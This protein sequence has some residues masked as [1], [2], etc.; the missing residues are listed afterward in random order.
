MTNLTHKLRLYAGVTLFTIGAIAALPLLA[1][2]FTG[3]WMAARAD[4]DGHN[5]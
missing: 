3:F 5:V 2:A 4:E 1:V